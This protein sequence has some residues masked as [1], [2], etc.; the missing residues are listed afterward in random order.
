MLSSSLL[1]GFVGVGGLIYLFCL[2]LDFLTE[3]KNMN[4]GG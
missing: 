1:Y 2:V 3:K 4:L